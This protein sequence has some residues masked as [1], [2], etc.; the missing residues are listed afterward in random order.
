MVQIE[1]TTDRAYDRRGAQWKSDT[2]LMCSNQACVY[3]AGTSNLVTQQERIRHTCG[4]GLRA[5][6]IQT[7]AECIAEPA[8]CTMIVSRD[9]SVTH[10]AQDQCFASC[11]DG[12]R[13]VHTPAASEAIVPKTFYYCPALNP[14]NFDSAAGNYRIVPHP[15]LEI[16]FQ[17]GASTV[18][19]PPTRNRRPYTSTCVADYGA[20]EC[21]GDAASTGLEIDCLKLACNNTFVHHGLNHHSTSLPGSVTGALVLMDPY[22]PKYDSDDCLDAVTLD[23]CVVRCGLGWS[24]EA[25]STGYDGALVTKAALAGGWPYHCR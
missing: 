8:N 19:P 3:A 7:D 5:A 21:A 15:F 24:P 18:G 23:T 25:G 10:A 6:G 17:A 14:A 9:V 11:L 20:G 2:Q 4:G 13:H 1:D 22:E 12:F 16:G